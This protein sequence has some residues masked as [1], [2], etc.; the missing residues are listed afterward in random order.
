[1]PSAVSHEPCRDSVYAALRVLR[2][3]GAAGFF[4]GAALAG[5][6]EAVLGAALRAAG[7]GAG[8]FTVID[9]ETPP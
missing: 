2:F 6:A 1:M 4:F 3:A 5:F 9:S 8:A 7:F